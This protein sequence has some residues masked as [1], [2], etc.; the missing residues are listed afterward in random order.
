M[1]EVCTTACVQHQACGQLRA[2]L[3]GLLEKLSCLCDCAFGFLFFLSFSLSLF[4]FFNTLGEKSRRR[5]LNLFL[6]LK[7]ETF[8]PRIV[9]VQ[10]ISRAWAPS[11]CHPRRV[12]PVREGG[13]RGLL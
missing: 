9:A 13:V 5:T 1:G 4:F 12:T 2:R 3:M 8:G 10:W 6:A 7:S 11:S